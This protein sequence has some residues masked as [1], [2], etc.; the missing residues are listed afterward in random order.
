MTIKKSFSRNWQL[1]PNF[2]IAHLPILVRCKTKG[3]VGAECDLTAQLA[4]RCLI[5]NFCRDVTVTL[6]GSHR[7]GDG[8]I[9]SKNLHASLFNDDLSNEPNSFL[10]ICKN[11]YL[12]YVRELSPLT[13]D[14]LLLSNIF[15]NLQSQW[16]PYVG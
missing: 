11:L 1:K 15:K 3:A 13:L 10:I 5:A 7:M 8:R 6:K 9:F 14:V 4:I 2:F 12:K 16:S